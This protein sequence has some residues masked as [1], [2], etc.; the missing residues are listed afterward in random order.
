MALEAITQLIPHD[1]PDA[2]LKF[3]SDIFIAIGQ[4][5]VVLAAS[6]L[7]PATQSFFAGRSQRKRD[8]IARKERILHDFTSGFPKYLANYIVYAKFC[9]FSIDASRRTYLGM[10]KEKSGDIFFKSFSNILESQQPE[11][12][13]T[14]IET[15]YRSPC[16][17]TLTK[18]ID[19][20]VDALRKIPFD[21]K[22]LD[23]E[24]D[25]INA[26]I[27]RE[28]DVL[29]QELARELKIDIGGK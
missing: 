7:F 15:Y 25:S 10:T 14:S 23:T 12:L 8:S 13:L 24:C 5:L 18:S 19:K 4:A 16:I 26:D 1:L 20:K 22:A 3:L 2:Q 17:H 11:S 28:Y 29:V 9:S 6:F 21:C 27:M